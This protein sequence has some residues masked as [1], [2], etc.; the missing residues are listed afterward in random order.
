MLSGT[1]ALCGTV[2][3]AGAHVTP[4][5]PPE[6]LFRTEALMP[7]ATCW[8]LAAEALLRNCPPR[9]T[10]PSPRLQML[11]GYSQLVWGARPGPLASS[12]E[13]QLQGS[14]GS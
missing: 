7:G 14:L 10:L 12:L 11:P 1:H 13:S 5:Y 8:L 4:P 9:R 3:D 6:A 2:M